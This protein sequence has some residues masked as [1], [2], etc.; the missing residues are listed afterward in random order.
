MSVQQGQLSMGRR[1]S[2][3]LL[4]RE[5]ELEY[6]ML[7]GASASAC[8]LGRE[9]ARPPGCEEFPVW[10]WRRVLVAAKVFPRR[11]VDEASL[12]PEELAHG[13]VSKRQKWM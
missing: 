2:Q 4:W 1:E 13:P 3:G 6:A 10:A 9:W 12:A 8:L 11:Q 7:Q 5:P